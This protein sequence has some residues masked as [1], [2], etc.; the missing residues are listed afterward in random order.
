MNMLYLNQ[1]QPEIIS[2]FR[3]ISRLWHGFLERKD[4]E[5]GQ[6]RMFDDD[7]E[8]QQP[9]KRTRPQPLQGSTLQAEVSIKRRRAF[10]A[11]RDIPLT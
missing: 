2:N 9:A 4:R 3:E 1:L 7:K 5:F 10:C 8:L 11:P 6:K